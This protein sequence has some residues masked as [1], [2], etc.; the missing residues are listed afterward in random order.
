MG[1]NRGGFAQE[2]GNHFC[3]LRAFVAVA[4]DFSDTPSDFFPKKLLATN[5]VTFFCY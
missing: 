3:Q 2:E 5:L 4:G 1:M